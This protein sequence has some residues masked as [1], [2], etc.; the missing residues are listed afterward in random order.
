[1]TV[2]MPEFDGR[3]ISVPFSFKEIVE[4]STVGGAVT[5]YVPVADRV[6]T[7]VGLAVRLARLRHKPN[8]AKRVTILLSSYPTKAAR[9]GNAVGLDSP[10]SLLSLLHALRQAGYDLGSAPLPPDSDSLIQA[11]IA[12]G[13]YD[14]E[15]L[16]EDQL[17]GAGGPGTCHGVPA[18]VRALASPSA[19]C[20][21]GGLGHTAR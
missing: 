17:R 20:S 15:F 2:A 4:E 14:T 8:A 6:Q 7:V 21:P 12:S 16:T 1:M 3:I 10:A 19:E 5:K 13:T 11:L 18:L 9:L